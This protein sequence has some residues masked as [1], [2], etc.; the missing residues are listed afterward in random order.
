MKSMKIHDFP[1]WLL[2]AKNIKQVIEKAEAEVDNRFTKKEEND[3]V[4]NLI[5]F[6]LADD[7]E[8]VKIKYVKRR[9]D[10]V[11]E[12]KRI[13]R[14]YYV[15]KWRYDLFPDERNFGARPSLQKAAVIELIKKVNSLNEK[16]DSLPPGTLNTLAKHGFNEKMFLWHLSC[17]VNAWEQQK[18]RPKVPAKK[19]Y[20]DVGFLLNQFADP[21]SFYRYMNETLVKSC[22]DMLQDSN[23]KDLGGGTTKNAEEMAV[24]KLDILFKKYMAFYSVEDDQSFM[25]E[26]DNSD[27]ERERLKNFIQEIKNCEWNFIKKTL[28]A[29]KINLTQRFIKDVILSE[30]RECPNSRIEWFWHNRSELYK[31]IEPKKK[32]KPKD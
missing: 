12:I 26:P 24:I 30:E 6:G 22:K 32:K 7:D 23:L 16:L 25:P 29:I 9:N 18:S 11:N 17:V 27:I 31:Q 4:R 13:L 8:L 15:F 5:F 20:K 1:Q 19:L 2:D 21:I 10:F 28:I 3:I 14:E